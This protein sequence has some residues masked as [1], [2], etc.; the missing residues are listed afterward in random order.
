MKSDVLFLWEEVEEETLLE[1]LKPK[2][3]IDTVHQIPGALLWM[4]DREKVNQSRLKDLLRLLVYKQ[5]TV[6]NVNTTRKIFDIM[7]K[8]HE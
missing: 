1:Q 6:R 3:A 2:V 7:T 8:L 4:V 5:T